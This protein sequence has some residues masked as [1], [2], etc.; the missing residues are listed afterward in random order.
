MREWF[1][2][3]KISTVKMKEKKNAIKTRLIGNLNIGSES[4]VTNS[5]INPI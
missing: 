3:K 1:Q 2:K 5:E 4:E